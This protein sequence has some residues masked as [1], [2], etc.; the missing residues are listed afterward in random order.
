MD[1][2]SLI[3]A[4]MARVL[5]I[6]GLIGWMGLACISAIRS[7]EVSLKQGREIGWPGR[8]GQ[9]SANSNH[10]YEALIVFHAV[11][12]LALVIENARLPDWGCRIGDLPP[13]GSRTAIFTPAIMVIITF[14]TDFRPAS[15]IWFSSWQCGLCSPPTCLPVDRP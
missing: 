9:I 6:F 5:M 11:G 8:I 14:P 4:L 13:A 3:R 10:R 2:V 7:G 1:G 12:L 15:S